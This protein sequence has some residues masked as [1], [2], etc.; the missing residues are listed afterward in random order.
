MPINRQIVLASRPADRI[1]EDNFRLLESP[2]PVPAAGQVLVRNRWLSVDPY[3]RGRMA[4]GKSYAASVE[5][6]GVMVGDTAGEVLESNHAGFKPGDTVVAQLGWQLYGVAEG[7]A[8]RKVDSSQLPLYAYLGPAGMPG[9][10]AYVGILDICAPKPG[11]TVAVTAASGAV[12]SIAGQLAK[13]AGCRVVGVAGGPEK[14]RYVQEEL[15]FD[16]CVDYK[17]ADFAAQLRAATPDGVD[18]LFENV[19]GVVFDTLLGCLNPFSRIALCGAISRL[20]NGD[21]H[22]ITRI[23][24]LIVNRV[25]LRGF[26]VSDHKS[27]WP[28]VIEELAGHLLADR[29]RY[30]VSIAEGLAAAPAALMGLFEGRNL[31]KQLVRL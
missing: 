5:L 15:G 9:I 25:T 17:A 1:L 10:T 12:G 7:E 22:G 13:L 29:I 2:V 30:Q 19:G 11:E 18:C 6:G 23:L 28:A 24:S 27:R 8:L 31:G 20:G 4:E 3:M 21:M 14:C 26:I 16:A